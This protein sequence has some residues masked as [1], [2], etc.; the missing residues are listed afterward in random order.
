MRNRREIRRGASLRSS[1]ASLAPE[2]TLGASL[3]FR[4]DDA[5]NGGGLVDSWPPWI[6]AGTLLPLGDK[7]SQSATDASLNNRVSVPFARTANVQPYSVSFAATAAMSYGIVWRFGAGVANQ[8]GFAHTSGGSLN[9]AQSLLKTSNSVFG[10]GMYPEFNNA[11]A[12]LAGDI[13]QSAVTVVVYQVGQPVRMY[14]NSRTAMVSSSNI[15]SL[16]GNQLL[17]GGLD[18]SANYVLSGAVARLAFFPSA[19]SAGQAAT[20]LDTYGALYGITISP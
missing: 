19:L 11:Q 8:G 4:A 2:Q 17:I 3:A 9:T 5:V 18:A 16:T 13:A 12:G 7:T 14:Y 20:F 1:A 15:V 10:R 6:G